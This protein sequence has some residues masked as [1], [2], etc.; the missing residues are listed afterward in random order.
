[1]AKTVHALVQCD[2]GM[3]VPLIRQNKDEGP[4]TGRFYRVHP[5]KG[6]TFCGAAHYFPPEID[7]LEDLKALPCP[8]VLK[9]VE[10][11]EK[12]FRPAE[13]KTETKATVVPVAEPVKEGKEDGRDDD[14]GHAFGFF[15]N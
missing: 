8:P 15:G 12:K 7:N 10:S 9:A 1:M 2:C 6:G 13:N 4:E 14:N 5:H 11:G 3:F